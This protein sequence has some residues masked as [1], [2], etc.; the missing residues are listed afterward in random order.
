MATKICVNI[1]SGYGSMA[2]GTK[3]LPEAMVICG[4]RLGVISQYVLTN[5][6]RIMCSK[7]PLK[8]S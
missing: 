7:I 2:E 1:N 5:F 3:P 4:I 8:N 6:I